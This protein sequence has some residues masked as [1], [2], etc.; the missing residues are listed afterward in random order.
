MGVVQLSKDKVIGGKALELAARIRESMVILR[1]LVRDQLP[2]PCTT[3]SALKEK[4]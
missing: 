3:K 1:S 2:L 4:F